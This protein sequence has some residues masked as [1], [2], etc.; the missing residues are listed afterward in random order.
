MQNHAPHAHLP[1][2]LVDKHLNFVRE[3]KLNLEIFFTN[4]GFD[5]I[6]DSDV[7][8]LKDKFDHN[9]RLSFH[10]P[11]MDLSPGAVD[12][13][14]RKATMQRF[15]RTLDFA[16]ILKAKVIVFH[17]GYERWKYAHNTDI[18]L[19]QS[20]KTWMPINERAIDI[21]VKVAI[22][23][24][25]EDEPANLTLLAK[26]MDSPNFGLCFDTGHF[27]LFAKPTLPEWLQAIKP[28]IISAHLHDNNTH[29]DEHIIPGEGT[30]DFRT[31]FREMKDVEFL[32]T[33]EMHKIEDI[34]KS[35]E[36]IKNYMK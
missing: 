28:Y 13:A 36:R 10:A 4:K 26:E 12:A 1:F 29:A 5:D 33:I 23:N 11:F 15:S 14:V 34:L 17:S 24:V 25:F 22:E 16:E 21:G 8:A 27:N 18:W 31:F 9:P 7:I 19:E 35:M 6:T 30:F 2:K 32:Q 20:L 3:H